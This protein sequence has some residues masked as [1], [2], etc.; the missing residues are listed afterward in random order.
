[1]WLGG[2]G[3]ID[4][5]GLATNLVTLMTSPLFADNPPGTKLHTT[6]SY[7]V[8]AA[9]A[10]MAL[11]LMA[12]V[13]MMI[14]GRAKG[15]GKEEQGSDCSDGIGDGGGGEAPAEGLEGEAFAMEDD[16]SDRQ[17]DV[18]DPGLGD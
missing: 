4:A 13:V 6:L 1:M 3:G 5:A 7:I 18:E 15:K 11:S 2:P 12:I 14:G 9:N 16:D 10:P 8:I 17:G